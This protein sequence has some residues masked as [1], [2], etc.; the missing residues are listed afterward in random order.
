MAAQNRR[1][2]VALAIPAEF[3]NTLAAHGIGEGVEVPELRDVVQ[4]PMMGPMELRVAMTIVG[5]SFQMRSG[6]GGRLRATVRAAASIEIL[7]DTPMMMLPGLVRVSGE[8]LVEPIVELRADGSFAAYL[9]L[10]NSELIATHFDGVDGVEADADAAA[11]MGQMLFATVGGDLFGGLADN[12][13][14]LGLELAPEEGVVIAELGVAPGRADVKVRS[15]SVEVG[16]PAADHLDGAASIVEVH[17]PCVGV[18]VAS[19]AIAALATALAQQQTG[20]SHLPF[21]LDVTT[22]DHQVGGRVRSTRLVNSTLL[23]DLRPG[24][25]YAVEPRLVDDHVELVLRAAWFE[26]PLVPGAVNRL[27]RWMGGLA[28]RALSPLVGPIAVR[29][30]ASAELPARPDSDVT[31]SVAVRSIH[32]EPEG[33]GAVVAADID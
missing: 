22:S 1:W 14:T 2:A 12:L 32:V 6:D 5:V 16:L 4:L 9:D 18:G 24:V 23:P 20:L 26:L 28:T 19:G 17:G 21:E 11:Q 25:S 33:V 31:M 15:G 29:L 13:G 8:V 30:P 7:G 3:L 10:P 27:N